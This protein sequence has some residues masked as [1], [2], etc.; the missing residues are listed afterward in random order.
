MHD[1]EECININI[2]WDLT[3]TSVNECVQVSMG[4]WIVGYVDCMHL[5]FECTFALILLVYN[6]LSTYSVAGTHNEC[7]TC[8]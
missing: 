7:G 6:F 2:L 8:S 1:L 5:S 3:F 4:G